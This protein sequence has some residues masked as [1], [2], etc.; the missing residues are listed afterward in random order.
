[1]FVTFAKI[2]YMKKNLL[3]IALLTIMCVHSLKA[4]SLGDYRTKNIGNWSAA[5]TWQMF[6]GVTWVNALL[7]PSNASGA[8]TIRDSVQIADTVFADQITID[9]GVVLLVKGRL[10][11]M[12]GIGTDLLCKGRLAVAATGNVANDTLLG[13]STISYRAAE[14]NTAGGVSPDIT[15]EGP[16]TQTINGPGYFSV[17]IVNNP[18]NVIVAGNEGF[19]GVNFVE[20]RVIVSGNLLVSQYGVGFSGQ[21]AKRFIDG[22]VVCIIYDKSKIT[23]TLPIGKNGHYS[24]IVLKLQQ[25]SAVQTEVLVSSRDTA[26]AKRTLPA[27]LDR[28]STVRFVNISKLPSAGKIT[29]AYLQM[30]YDSTDGVK[31]PVNLRIARSDNPIWKDL[32]GVGTGSPGGSITVS[33]LTTLPAGGDFV[34]ANATGG[35]NTLPLRFTSF[36]TNLV[37]QNAVMLNWTTAEELNT[38]HFNVQRKE[39][40]NAAWQTI[41]NVAAAH[42]STASTY[43]YLDVN[44]KNNTTYFYQIQEVDKNGNIYTSKTLQ[45]RTGGTA[46]MDV[47]LMYPNPARDVLNYYVSSAANDAVTVTVYGNNGKTMQSQKVVANQNLQVFIKTLPAGIYY[48]TVMNNK[49]GEKV[50]KKFVKL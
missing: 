13:G 48:F 8:I 22:D 31:D 47:N 46:G 4:Q 6:N 28:V 10:V 35:A 15:F 37:K 12:N 20:G 27:T 30:W 29:S 1:M 38:G 9:S 50:T 40:N 5:T 43:N 21:N 32:G 39:G 36:T 26:P 14:L 16:V 34:L 42:Q 33:T 17:M 41:G 19:S 11:L 24:P 2:A 25:D 45:V 23:F 49:T 44:V 18:K 3:F 7:P